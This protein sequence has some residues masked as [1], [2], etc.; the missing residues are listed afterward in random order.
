MSAAPL[1]SAD[2][3]LAALL[4]G[5]RRHDTAAQGALYER[6]ALP[7]LAVA[8][9]YAPSRAD[10]EDAL[11]E[12][13]IKVFQK[14]DDQRDPAAFPGWVRRIVVRTAITAWHRRRLRRT[15]FELEDALHVPTPD[16]DALD[17]LTLAE[18]KALID[19]LPAGCRLVMLL[20]TIEGY[21]HPEI[22]ELLGIAEAASR[23]QLARARQRLTVLVQAASHERRPAPAPPPGAAARPPAAT[24]PPAAASSAPSPTPFHPLTTLLFQ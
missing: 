20:A 15:D 21:S 24:L 11:Q 13:F 5:C 3:T 19:K 1:P 12:A 8:Q 23:M 18:V 16:G 10:A 4:A 9:R 17:H 6:F 22:S 7:M 14:L 2:P